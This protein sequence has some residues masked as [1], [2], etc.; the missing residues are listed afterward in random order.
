MSKLQMTVV[1]GAILLV[2]GGCA[3]EVPDA[4]APPGKVAK[5]EKHKHVHGEWWCDEH[6]VPEEICARC[7]PQLVAQ[8]KAKGDW[9]E[10][11]DRPRSQCF[12][13]EPKLFD[14]FA[15]QYEAKMGKKPPRPVE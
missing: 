2:A 14:Q 6:G 4:P 5:K 8:F 11:H 1:L 7:Q 10:K 15:A 12:I 9:C 13:C 3:R